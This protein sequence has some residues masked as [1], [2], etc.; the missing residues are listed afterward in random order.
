MPAHNPQE[1]IEKIEAI[2]SNG[3]AT[4]VS[5]MGGLGGGE[6][7]VRL[8]PN[9]E[10]F[11]SFYVAEP[12]P[13]AAVNKAEIQRVSLMDELSGVN[14]Q[15]SAIKLAPADQ[16]VAQIDDAVGKIRSLKTR[17]EAPQAAIKPEW[18]TTLRHKLTHIDETL[19][20]TLNKMGIEYKIP[21][22]ADAPKTPLHRFLGLL[23]NGQGQLEAL[24][25]EIKN[26]QSQATLSPQDMLGLQYKVNIV[27][28]QLEL[29]TS[30][31]N[32]ALESTKSVMNTQ[33]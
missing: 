28:Q 13:V 32:K 4:E 16:I 18:Q 27:Q 24:G 23:E 8:S 10:H 31:L 22:I 2:G 17:I 21:E 1:F 25:G 29:F 5:P 7:E 9:K 6:P 15:V 3:G 33:V 20:V 14:K 26:M 19:Q 12:Q 30:C 11:D